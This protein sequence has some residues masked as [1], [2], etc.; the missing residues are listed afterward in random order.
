VPL[1]GVE[2][3]GHGDAP[4]LHRRHDL[5]RLG[6]LDS[7]VV[8]P[9]G[10]EQWPDDA[11]DIGQWRVSLQQR[12]PLFG[13]V[14]ANA[15]GEQF[16]HRLPVRRNRLQQR[17]Q[18]RRPNDVHATGE[19]LRVERQPG[20]RRV[21]A[22]TAT[23]DRHA[24][25]VGDTLGDGPLHAVLLIFQ[26]LA[27][28]LEVAGV[29]ERLAEAGGRAEVDRQHGVAPVGQPLVPAVEAP[30][31]APP[32]AAVGDE[33]QG[34][35]RVGDA[36]AIAVAARREGVVDDQVQPVAGGNDRRTHL[37]QRQPFQLGAVGEQEVG[38]P[39]LAVVEIVARRAVVN[40]VGHQPEAVVLRT[41][42]DLH[43]TIGHR[44]QKVE[45]RGNCRVEHLPLLAV[46]DEGHRLHVALRRMAQHLVGVG[47]LIAGQQ[48][49]LA[50]RYVNSHQ[51]G[52]IAIATVAQ[53]EDVAAL[54]EAGG[55]RRQHVRG[56]E[57][58][59]QR[60]VVAI[61][62]KDVQPAGRRHLDRG[63][64]GQVV[65]NFHAYEAVVFQQQRPLAAGQVDAIDV[66][67]LR[68]AVVESHKNFVRPVMAQTNDLRCHAVERG[69]V[70]HFAGGNVGRVNAPVLIPPFVL[71]VED[72]AAG[73]GPGIEA[74]AAPSVGR[75]RAGVGR[76]VA[77]RN[78][79]VQHAVARGQ[80]GQMLAV[81]ANGH[82]RPVGVTEKDAAG[83]EGQVVGRHILSSVR[84]TF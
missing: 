53:I 71:D 1:I 39:P 75:H 74:N 45:V 14:V 55:G 3:V 29:G 78:P 31:I 34:Q 17:D 9:L 8:S 35:R 46:V 60:P 27:A 19:H 66:V 41:A 10:D 63:A 12:P 18:V 67:P 65:I 21:A 57:R 59:P 54:V 69:Q 64:D 40:D 72:V 11:I 22:K 49:A 24:R 76:T 70:A 52:R 77:R 44:G 28:P 81:G 47:A 32:G 23:H 83:D 42:G 37:G 20:Q 16:D 58:L 15:H 79:D 73:V 7:R 6:L 2:G 68:V 48:R 25:R 26:Y 33:D 51:C 62:P 56:R 84:R 13:A 4:G 80:P 50:S 5:V 38:R 43:L 61:S 82:L 36:V 30:A